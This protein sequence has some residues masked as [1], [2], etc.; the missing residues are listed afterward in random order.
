MSKSE[1]RLRFGAG[2]YEESVLGLVLL[3]QITL[4][5]IFIF[6]I[7]VVA[8]LTIGAIISGRFVWMQLFT[9]LAFLAAFG[10]VVYLLSW[11]YE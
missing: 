6:L 9:D 1:P 4:A 11:L 2:G 10:L 7:L 3:V 5:A 8:H